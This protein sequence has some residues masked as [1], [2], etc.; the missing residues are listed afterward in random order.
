LR[1]SQQ[2]LQAIFRDASLGIAATDL[3]G[4]FTDA[5]ETYCKMLG[6]TLDELKNLNVLELTHPDD[7]QANYELR[8]QLICGE[9]EQFVYEKRY[10]VRSGAIL[11]CRISASP[12]HDSRGNI[13]GLRAGADDYLAK[14]FEME[15]MLAR[16][17]ALIR[18]AA[19]HSSP[20]LECGPLRL[21]TTTHRFT[22]DA[23]PVELTALEFRLV[24]Y[25]LHHR[26]KVV[27]KTELSEHIY[28]YDE[29]RDSNTIEVLINRLRKKLAPE[30]IRTHRG[31]GYQLVDPNHAA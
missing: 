1:E 6:Y 29:D 28:G 27:S 24:S 21:D 16:V 5:N 14:P 11:W 19:G 26:G 13:M 18:R 2:R 8:R 30:L 9:R 7:R 17:E 22:M 3:T 10:F 15:E 31:Q 4:H 23:A 25:L 12:L 20:V